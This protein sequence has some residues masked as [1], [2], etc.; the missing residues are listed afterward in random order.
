MDAFVFLKRTEIN[1]SRCYLQLFL[2]GKL[3]TEISHEIID[4]LFCISYFTMN[5]FYFHNQ[6]T[7]KIFE[8]R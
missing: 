7:L 4:L 6:E 5:M 1:V 8:L 2:G 3:V